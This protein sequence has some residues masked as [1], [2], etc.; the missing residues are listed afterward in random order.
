MIIFNLTFEII[1]IFTIISNISRRALKIIFNLKLEIIIIFTIISNIKILTLL[2]IWLLWVS[3]FS[4]T[5]VKICAIVG[6]LEYK[7]WLLEHLFL[8]KSEVAGPKPL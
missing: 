7:K 2:K 1:V 5:V 6:R 8:K 4:N 3:C